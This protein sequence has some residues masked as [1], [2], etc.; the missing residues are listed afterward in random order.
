MADI[1]LLYAVVA[2]VSWGVGDFLIQRSARKVGDWEA[3][4]FITFFASIVLFPFCYP[5]LKTLSGFDWLV[6]AGTSAVILAAALFDFSALRVGKIAVIEPIYA[7]EVPITIALATFLVG[8][9]LSAVQLGLI[10]LLLISVLLVTTKSFRG[11]HVRALERGIWAALLGT[12]GM[13]A[14]N[15]LFGY[16]SR[17]AGPLMVNWFTSVFMAFATLAYLLYNER[18]K[19]IIAHVR[20]NSKLLFAM[21]FFDLLAWIGYSA[22]TLSLPIGLVTGLTESYI[23]LSVILGLTFNKEKLLLHQKAGL[24]L[25]VIAAVTLAFSAAS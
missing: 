15:F 9:H 1:G 12:I 5:A 10:V 22:S 7:M 11:M 18:G 21:S 19:T 4:F 24:A 2:I 14:S 13:G 8:E 23:A 6:L 20:H 3:L 17:A 25:A 16:T